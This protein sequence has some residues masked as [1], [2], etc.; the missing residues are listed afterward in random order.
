MEI[1]LSIMHRHNTKTKLRQYA[2]AQVIDD[3]KVGFYFK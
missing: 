2:T 1:Q 3:F